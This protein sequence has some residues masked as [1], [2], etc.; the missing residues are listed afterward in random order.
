MEHLGRYELTTALTNKN[1]GS[2]EWCFGVLNG[3]EYFIKAFKEPKHPETDTI[4]SP[5]KKVK[6]LKRCQAFERKKADIYRTINQHSDG[7]AARI[8]EL[9]RVGS[10][11]YMAMPKLY[12]ISMDAEDIARLP[13]HVKRRICAIIAHAVSGLHQG[14]F[15]HADIKHTNVM[16]VYSRTKKLTAKVIDYDAGYFESD[17]PTN[18]EEISGDPVYLAPETWLALQE[19]PASLTCKLDVFALG[20]LFHQYLAGSLP[21][22]DESQFASA[23]EAVAL[24]QALTVSDTLPQELQTLLRDMLEADPE[25]R[26]N[27]QDV[28]S[29]LIAP[30]LPAPP[31]ITSTP[32]AGTSTFDPFA[33]GGFHKM[34][35]L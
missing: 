17:P 15:V 5:E 1:A 28:Y 18:P 26:P 10:T 30:L 35:D 32:P 8:T 4:S 19:E 24:G 23:G 27:A 3:Q 2:C 7:N 6:K 34:D 21:G 14:G 12:P 11:Y 13:D 9:F 31:A 22:Y 25:K 20:V 33:T 16:I 29:V